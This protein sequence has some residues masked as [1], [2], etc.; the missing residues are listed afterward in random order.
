MSHSPIALVAEM[1][2]A[3]TSPKSPRPLVGHQSFGGHPKSAV[4]FKGARQPRFPVLSSQG[5]AAK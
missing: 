1:A 2:A 3:P 5:W 4:S